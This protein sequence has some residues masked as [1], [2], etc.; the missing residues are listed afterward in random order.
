MSVPTEAEAAARIAQ[1]DQ[2]VQDAKQ[3]LHAL[4]SER[5]HY[6]SVTFEFDPAQAPKGSDA[7]YAARLLERAT[8][9][10]QADVGALISGFLETYTSW[11]FENALPPSEY[12]HE[13][14]T[15]PCDSCRQKY[16]PTPTQIANMALPLT[17]LLESALDVVRT[18][19]HHRLGLDL[20]T[21][22][23]PRLER[24]PVQ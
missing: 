14:E 5:G 7:E 1:A 6:K 22:L 4:Q 12:L 20:A 24:N 2:A 11:L 17:A 9:Y 13:G 19:V 15:E 16:G 21:T 3:V 18:N 23:L 10:V 8:G